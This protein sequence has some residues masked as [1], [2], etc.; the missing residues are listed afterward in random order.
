M[1]PV[2]SRVD[3]KQIEDQKA[4]KR[5]VSMIIGRIRAAA[6]TRRKKVESSQYQRTPHAIGKKQLDR[7]V[8]SQAESGEYDIHPAILRLAD[9]LGLDYSQ[10]R[11]K[12]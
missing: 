2:K 10:N 9:D 8:V 1:A 12:R 11:A 5:A 6:G 3:Q 7:K 4:L